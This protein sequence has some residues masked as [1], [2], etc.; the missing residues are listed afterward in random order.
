MMKSISIIKL[1]NKH[2]S[3]KILEV[4]CGTGQ[5]AKRFLND[6]YYYTGIDI[7]TPMLEY[8]EK[9]LPSQ[10]FHEM[11]MRDI[12]LSGTFDAVIITVRSISYILINHD[13]IATLESVKNALDVGGIFNL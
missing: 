4:G 3:K 1:V 11:D 10:H 2:G 6:G 8:A 12:K 7:S 5:L 9:E 13:V